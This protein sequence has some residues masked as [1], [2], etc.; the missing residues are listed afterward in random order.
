MQYELIC[1]ELKK[2][3]NAQG[4]FEKFVPRIR[5][6]VT[7]NLNEFKPEKTGDSDYKIKSDEGEILKKI[8]SKD[9]VI[10]LDESGKDFKS[11]VLSAKLQEIHTNFPDKKIIFVLGGPY[12]L[13]AEIRK[14]ADLSLSLSRLTFNSE[15]ASIVFI[16]QL[17][18]ILTIQFDH[19]YHNE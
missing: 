11:I 6:Y 8:T 17:Y 19:P 5:S 15:I 18:R 2:F 12:G 13:G 3:K 14:R 16:E 4:V 1:P 9:F 10:I 7:F